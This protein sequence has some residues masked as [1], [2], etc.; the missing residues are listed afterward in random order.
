[1]AGGAQLQ[2]KEA[3]LHIHLV[4]SIYSGPISLDII[5]SSHSSNYLALL[6]QHATTCFA[7]Q[8]YRNYNETKV[9]Y[10]KDRCWPIEAGKFWYTENARQQLN[11][12]NTS[13]TSNKHTKTLSSTL[14]YAFR[15]VEIPASNCASVGWHCLRASANVPQRAMP[16]ILVTCNLAA[17][18]ILI[19]WYSLISLFQLA[20][21][22][23]FPEYPECFSVSRFNIWWQCPFE[24]HTGKR[25]QAMQWVHKTQ[26]SWPSNTAQK[27]IRHKA[28]QNIPLGYWTIPFT[29]V[30]NGT[31]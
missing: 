25:N 4:S 11:C 13:K 19:L 24:K 1:M 20:R 31:Q 28:A 22:G 2:W 10:W 6:L 17:C 16:A 23:P 30:C 29:G 18:C 26:C 14:T 9:K 21:H 12:T 8:N 7:N 5:S 15:Q 3:V 27:I